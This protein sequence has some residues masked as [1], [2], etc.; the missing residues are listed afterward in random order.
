MPKAFKSPKE[1]D[2][3]AIVKVP[4]K[5]RAIERAFFY[6]SS[7]EEYERE[8]K[9][10]IEQGIITRE[11]LKNSVIEEYVIGAKFNANYVLVTLNRRH[12]PVRL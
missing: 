12:R 5:E 8:A 3:L 7:P 4:E 11:A 1:I 10:R 2:R 6:A 9:K